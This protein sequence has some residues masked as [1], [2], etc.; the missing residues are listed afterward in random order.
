MRFLR[1]IALVFVTVGC[2]EPSAEAA[3]VGTWVLADTAAAG[4]EW[5]PG[6]AG[7]IVISGDQKFTMNLPGASGQQSGDWDLTNDGSIIELMSAS[8][9]VGQREPHVGFA[10]LLIGKGVSSPHYRL[11]K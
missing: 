2:T 1:A 10:Y 8:G 6:P 4:G 5:L 9:W 11:R 7:T 3:Y